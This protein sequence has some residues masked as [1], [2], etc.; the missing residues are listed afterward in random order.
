M[1]VYLDTSVALAQLL[2]EDTRPAPDLWLQPLIASRLLEY[3]IATRLSNLG[4]SDAQRSVATVLL[5][6][7][8]LIELIPEILQHGL[9]R[10]LPKSVRTLDRLHIAS[11]LYLHEQGVSLKL[12]TYDDRMRE[13]ALALQIPLYHP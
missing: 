4:V 3:E 13:V 10:A 1:M 11:L 8:A 9:T 2:A 5:Q 7:V 6:R 12:A